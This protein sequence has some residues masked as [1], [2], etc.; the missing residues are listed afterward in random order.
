VVAIK[1]VQ[2]FVVSNCY[3]WVLTLGI[4]A[5]NLGF[6]LKASSQIYG[7]INMAYMP[8]KPINLI[9]EDYNL[10]RP[11][12][13]T[14]HGTMNMMRGF[15]VGLGL[16][17]RGSRFGLFH[18]TW[19]RASSGSEGVTPLTNTAFS[20]ETRITYY[21][22]SFFDLAVSN[23]NE[24]KTTGFGLG[25]RL[26]ELGAFIYESRTFLSDETPGTYRKI[27]ANNEILNSNFG[28][29][30][31]LQFVPVSG[32]STHLDVSLGYHFFYFRDIIPEIANEMNS[33]VNL[34]HPMRLRTNYLSL[35][36]NLSFN[37]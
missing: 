26:L 24:Q 23:T 20:R 21:A 29:A 9:I 4:I 5:A 7:G 16:Q 12:L 8:H 37:L 32:K 34:I 10:K 25:I 17:A 11:W 36:L 28:S 1:K 22:F 35:S 6:P 3:V 33:N 27:Y 14:E 13:T 30:L 2:I 31:F 15:N 19:Q 18:F